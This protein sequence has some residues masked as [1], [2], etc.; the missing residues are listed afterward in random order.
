MTTY[1]LAGWVVG[2]THGVPFD[3][4]VT[5]ECTIKIDGAIQLTS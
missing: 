5:L 3:D 4:A 1:D 2:L